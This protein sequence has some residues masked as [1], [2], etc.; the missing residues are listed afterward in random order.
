MRPPSPATLCVST[1]PAGR[2]EAYG[3]S[4]SVHPI[5]LGKRSLA[6]TVTVDL[7]EPAE[8]LQ[9]EAVPVVELD[10]FLFQQA[11]LEGVTAIAG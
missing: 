11:L 7:I 4:A 10:A 1:L 6:P 5:A 2:G 9:V 8:S 3:V